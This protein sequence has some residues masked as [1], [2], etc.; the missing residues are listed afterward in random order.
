MTTWTCV[1][2]RR[3]RWCTKLRRPTAASRDAGQPGQAAAVAERGRNPRADHRRR[4]PDAARPRRQRDQSVRGKAR[5]TARNPLCRDPGEDQ[6]E[7]PLAEVVLDFFDKLKSVSRG[8][9]SMDYHFL[10][11]RAG[12]FVRLV[13]SSMATAWMRCR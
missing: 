3:R 9:A 10:E 2:S 4:H 13:C 8:Y 12:P 7:L 5:C 1:N 6:P 11:F